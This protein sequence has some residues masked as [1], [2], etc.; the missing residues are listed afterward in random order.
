MKKDLILIVGPTAAG[1]TAISIDIARKIAGEIISADSMQ[2]YKYMDI[3]TAK[4]TND[5]MQGIPHYLID[6]IY[7][8][9]KFTV[10]EFKKLAYNYISKIYNKNKFPIVVG[11][12]GLYINSLVYNLDFTKTVS[13]SKLRYNFNK[14]AK[15]K[16]N[17]YIHELLKEVDKK[18]YIRIH[19]ND[20]KRIVRALEVFYD[21][22][23]PM[24]ESYNK[25]REPNPDFNFIIFGITMDRKKLYKRINSRVD[26]MI[27]KGLVKEVKGLLDMGY[28]KNLVSM[29][30]L[31]YKEIISYINGEISLNDAVELLKRDTRRFAKRQLTWF[32][33]DNRIKWINIEE[34]KNKSDIISKIVSIIEND[35]NI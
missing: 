17:K 6:E 27:D 24:S 20:T 28:H 25:F 32:R 26:L 8:D 3:G 10:S 7:P 12:T 9:E 15:E 22:G 14:L 35:L 23:K 19:E 16:G 31:G 34:Y 2:I 18:S 29:Q 21:T 33:R 13:N 1:K 11:G 30:G 4:V 5:E